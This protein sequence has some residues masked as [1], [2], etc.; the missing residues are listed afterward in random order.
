MVS[1]RK[2]R[3]QRN[4]CRRWGGR[5][6]DSDEQIREFSQPPDEEPDDCDYND[7]WEDWNE[8]DWPG[9]FSVGS[10]RTVTRQPR[11]YR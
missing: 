4:Q 11:D 8:L 7:D 10:C 9:G 3:R 6:N 5:W 2:I 1:M